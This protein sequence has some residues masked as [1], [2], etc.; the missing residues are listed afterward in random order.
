MTTNLTRARRSL[1]AIALG[2]AWAF[3]AQ[4]QDYTPFPE[5]SAGFSKHQQ[6][7]GNDAQPVE[8]RNGYSAERLLDADVRGGDGEKLGNVENFLVDAD[9]RIS[10][11]VVASQGFLGVGGTRL[12]VPWSD[13]KLAPQLDHVQV[14]VREDS[15]SN[16]NLFKD[17]EMRVPAGTSRGTQ[18]MNDWISLSNGTL[19]GYVEDVIFAAD[20][21]L[22]WVVVT[23]ESR[24]GYG[25][26]AYPYQAQDTDR[27]YVGKPYVRPEVDE[28]R[29][30]DYATLGI[31]K[32]VAQ[33]P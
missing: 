6:R 19:F 14:P 10:S 18:L 7:F 5:L 3:A 11:I 27:A 13:V 21:A 26:Y 15:L 31:D 22:R 25:T 12:V 17:D 1:L 16:F 24:Q 32:Q 33:R 30:F 28:L 9:G 4:A 2:G 20:G 23:P 8:M 29:L